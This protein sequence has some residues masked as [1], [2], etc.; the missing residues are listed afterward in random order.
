MVMSYPICHKEEIPENSARGF[1]LE[2]RIDKIKFFVIRKNAKYFAYA[3]SCPHT[4]INL[5]WVPDQFLDSKIELIQ[6]SIH[7]AKFQIE[8]GHCIYEPCLGQKLKPLNIQ[9]EG[10]YLQLMAD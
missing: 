5:E 4:N 10:D 1:S 6:C 2:T 9:I 7:G 8:D 3:N